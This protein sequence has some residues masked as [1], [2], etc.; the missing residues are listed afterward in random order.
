MGGFAKV[1]I[2]QKIAGGGFFQCSDDM[3]QF[4]ETKFQNT[5]SVDYHFKSIDTALLDEERSLDL[6]IDVATVHGSSTFHAMVFSPGKDCFKA[7]KRICICDKCKD[8][9]GS[10]EQFA[11]YSLNVNQLNRIHLRSS[12]A[13]VSMEEPTAD[14]E[15][16]ESNIIDFLPENSFVAV[17]AGNN[18]I[19]TVWFVKIIDS[20]CLSDGSCVDDYGNAI[21]QGVTYLK[22][23]FLE[24]IDEKNDHK[25][26]K[27]SKKQ[28]FFYKESVVYPF[29]TFQET[30][31]GLKLKHS[32]LMDIIQFVEANNY[33]HI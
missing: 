2:R 29:V 31:K 17:A 7:S 20:D 3:V 14:E 18:S 15:D 10:C 22:G 9:F 1:A 16:G 26:Y 28:T 21:G 27:L 30:K 32:D 13:D 11:E 33:C 12:N 6:L 25:L 8:Q 24:K 4:L 5:S 23:H 19:D